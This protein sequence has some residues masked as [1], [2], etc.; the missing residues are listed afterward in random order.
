MKDSARGI[1]QEKTEAQSGS[2]AEQ[3]HGCPTPAITCPCS[4][5][6]PAQTAAEA[7]PAQFPTQALPEPSCSCYGQPK[8]IP[9]W[10]DDASQGWVRLSFSCFLKPGIRAGLITLANRSREITA[11]FMEATSLGTVKLGSNRHLV[12]V[13]SLHRCRTRPSV[14]RL[15][16]PR[17]TAVQPAAPGHVLPK[18][19]GEGKVGSRRV[20]RE[21]K[22]H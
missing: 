21:L 2:P 6:A 13:T 8:E 14:L 10:M 19:V 5:T 7:Q 12:S 18:A 4:H 1:P 11:A 22:R 3:P 17:G 9:S 16:G 15:P 20:L